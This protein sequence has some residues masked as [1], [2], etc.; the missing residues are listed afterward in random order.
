MRRKAWISLVPAVRSWI[1]PEDGLRPHFAF[2]SRSSEYEIVDLISFSE[3][4]HRIKQGYGCARMGFTQRGPKWI[5]LNPGTETTLSHLDLVY[6]QSYPG[7]YAGLSVAW[8]PSRCDLFED[9][10]FVH[11]MAPRLTLADRKLHS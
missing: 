9:D 6:H 5:A 8:Q 7:A 4:L 10:W 2:G 3:A 1:I 11:P